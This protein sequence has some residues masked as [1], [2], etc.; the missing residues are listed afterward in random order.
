MQH[1]AVSAKYRPLSLTTSFKRRSERSSLSRCTCKN[2][3]NGN[4]C[5]KKNW[6]SYL[7]FVDIDTIEVQYCSHCSQ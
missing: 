5:D 1:A 7:C 4:A 2:G 6:P 3:W